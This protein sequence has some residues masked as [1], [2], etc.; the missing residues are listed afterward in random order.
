M[1]GYQGLPARHHPECPRMTSRL[2]RSVGGVLLSLWSW[3][4]HLCRGQP[5]HRLEL[6]SGRRPSD[7]SMWH[8]KSWWEGVSFMEVWLHVQTVSCNDGRW[9]P[10]QDRDLSDLYYVFTVLLCGQQSFSE[11]PVNC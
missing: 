7:R 4:S 8:C 11:E 2:Q 10:A 3:S 9:D 5:E 1:R 6:G